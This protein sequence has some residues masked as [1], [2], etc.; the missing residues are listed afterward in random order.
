MKPT[1]CVVKAKFHY[2]I[3]LATSSRAGRRPDSE[4][5]SAMEYGVNRSA[6]RFELSRNVEITR[7]CLRQ[8]ANQVCDQVYD[9]DSVMEFSLNCTIRSVY[10]VT[11]KMI[12]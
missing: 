5:D 9:L 4:Q 10:A 8:V 2:T 6:T 7:T 1:D 11:M 12:V 3:Q